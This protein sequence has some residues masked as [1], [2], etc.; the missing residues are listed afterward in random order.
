MQQRRNMMQT[1][2]DCKSSE[3]A[4]TREFESI[5]EMEAAGIARTHST[6][7]ASSASGA[8]VNELSTHFIWQFGL[9]RR[10]REYSHF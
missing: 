1:S 7:A 10:L 8:S 3:L 5:S 9:Q 6:S 2:Q 4:D